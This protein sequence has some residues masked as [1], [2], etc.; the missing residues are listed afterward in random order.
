MGYRGLCSTH[1]QAE[2]K[3]KALRA[4]AK[5]KR[6]KIRQK[7]ADS[8]SKL[9]DVMDQVFSRFIRLRDTDRH[10][11]GFCID[12]GERMEWQD[13]DNGHFIPRDRLA[14]R[15]DEVNCAAQKTSC[16]RFHSGRQFEFALGLDKRYGEGTAK[17]VLERSYI[18]TKIPT[19]EL[20]E[21]IALCS[22]KVEKMLKEKDFVPWKR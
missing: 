7:R 12:C 14:T 16:N 19:V 13:L 22:E 11:V 5:D 9:R 18:V 1:Y 20:K 2:L 4:K 3:A 6:A 17:L 8:F 10:G 15:W 21:M